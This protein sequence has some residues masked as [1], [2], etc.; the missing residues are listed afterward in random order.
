MQIRSVF[1]LVLAVSLGAAA[2]PAAEARQGRGRD[3]VAADPGSSA[4]GA[5][6][7]VRLREKSHGRWE[8]RMQ[9]ENA[10]QGLSPSVFIADATGTLV[11]AGSLVPDDNDVGEYKLR[12]RSQKGGALP[13][14]AA[15]LA[16][17]G[18]RAYE[19]RENGGVIFAG[20]LPSVAAKSASASGADAGSGGSSTSGGGADDPATHDVGDDHGGG[21]A[22]DPA[23][24]DAGDDHGGRGSGGGRGRGRGSDDPAKRGADDGAGHVRRGRGADD[25]ARRR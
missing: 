16:D 21:G 10:P 4:A 6:L 1:A 3:D 8:F 15:T 25:A 14:G 18:G 22:D 9:M 17:L 24:H 23:D 11:L 5:S 12:L 7:S 13:A 19:V 2:L 20:T